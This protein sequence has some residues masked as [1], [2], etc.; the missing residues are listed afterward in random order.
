MRCPSP[1]FLL[2]TTILSYIFLAIGGLFI[3]ANAIFFVRN[4]RKKRGPSLIPFVGGT[5]VALAILNS[6]WEDKVYWFWVPFFLDMGCLPMFVLGFLKD[7]EKEDR[8][9]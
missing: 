5:T 6:L 9:N 8:D 3:L 4:I 1:H 2:A 7:N